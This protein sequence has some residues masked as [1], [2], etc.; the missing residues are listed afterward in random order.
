[1]VGFFLD[2]FSFFLLCCS[3][4]DELNGCHRSGMV[5]QQKSTSE[6]FYSK[7]A[8]IVSLILDRSRLPLISEEC[9]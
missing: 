6:A 4:D 8:M 3:H 1:M 2:S 5:P 9:F 7:N